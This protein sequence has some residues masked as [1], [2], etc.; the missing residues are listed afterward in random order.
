MTS[1]ELKKQLID[2]IQKIENPG[3][4]EEVFRLLE[5]ESKDIEIYKLNEEQKVAISE[6]RQQLKNG[7][8]LTEDQANQEIDEWLNK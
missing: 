1:I 6:A 8:F 3:I 5:L 4:L 2:K 7:Q